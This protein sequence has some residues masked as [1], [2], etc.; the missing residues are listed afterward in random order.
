M[1]HD[2]GCMKKSGRILRKIVLAAMSFRAAHPDQPAL[3]F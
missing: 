1:Q 2:A 3:L